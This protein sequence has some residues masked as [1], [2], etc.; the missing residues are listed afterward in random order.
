[1]FAN[2]LEPI[3]TLMGYLL[4]AFYAVVPNY[5]VSIMATTLVILVILTPLT[6]KQIRQGIRIQ[7][8]QPE[9]K[10]IQDDFKD[11]MEAK[12]T[13]MM[14]L[15]KEHNANP[16]SCILP[17]LVQFP[18]FISLSGTL[19]GLS[20]VHYLVDGKPVSLSEKE[21]RAKGV[22]E[23]MIGTPKHLPKGSS[24]FRSLSGTKIDLGHTPGQMKALGMDLA[25]SA[26]DVS[27]FSHLLPYVVV[28]A[29]SI[30]AGVYAQ[31]QMTSRNPAAM[32]ANP[33]QQQI[34]KMTPFL[35]GLWG[36]IFQGGLAVYFTTSS[37]L[38]IVQQS[39]LYKFD[40]TLTESVK[41]NHRKA[42]A[43]GIIEAKVKK[44]KLTDDAGASAR[45]TAKSPSLRP[46]TD[47][48]RPALPSTRPTGRQ[49]PK[50]KRKGR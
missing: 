31:Q 40:P 33:Q 13:A 22:F 50:K 24:L 20:S 17:M 44:P 1:M 6:L 37:V 7:K 19:R 27:G 47:G 39:L 18:F 14:A 29:L 32:A 2:V 12:N 5:A 48:P 16:V 21:A 28:I 15:Y 41:E 4:A 35:F 38:R 34:A 26:K 3:Y 11:D 8:L 42:V 43:E 10:K 23:S 25:K 46:A 36:F 9:L 30:L 45:N 49:Q